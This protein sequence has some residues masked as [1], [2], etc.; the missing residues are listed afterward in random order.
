MAVVK[1]YSEVKIVLVGVPLMNTRVPPLSLA[2]LRA[3]MLQDGYA[4]KCFDFNIET[5]RSVVPELKEQWTF[6]KGLQWLDNSY[7]ESFVYPNII[8]KNL[9]HWVSQILREKPAVVGISMTSSPSGILLAHELK[10]AKPDLKIIIGGPGCSKSF[11]NGN[12]S[13][14][15][16][17]DAVVHNEGELTLSALMKSYK[18]TGKFQ[19]V[20]GASVMGPNGE[21]LFTGLREPQMD[22][23]I[24]PT[25][26][27][28]D[29]NFEYY[30]D[31]DDPQQMRREIPYYATRG[32]P[33]RC[34][35][36]MDYKMWDNR[37]R[38]KSPAR[39]IQEMVFLS[40]KYKIKNFMLIELIFNGHMAKLKI[41]AE[42]LAKLKMGFQ[43]WGHGRIDP[44]LDRTTIQLLKDCGFF[45]FVF[46]L[47]SGSDKVLKAMRK[48]YNKETA[49]R[50][51][52]DMGEVG[53]LCSVNIVIGFPGE[54]WDDFWETIELVHKH[55]KAIAGPPSLS[56]CNAMPGSDIYLYPEK[57][58]IKTK[59]GEPPQ[60]L[61][62]ETVDGT[63]TQ[64]IRFF[65]RD[66]MRKYFFKFRFKPMG[67][68]HEDIELKDIPNPYVEYQKMK[69]EQK[70]KFEQEK[71]LST[72][73]QI[74]KKRKVIAKSKR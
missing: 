64:E 56:A 14:G 36:C 59:N 65:R 1:E 46:G 54:D 58:G 66:F 61:E 48:G 28:D 5:Y 38:Q 31:A 43:F 29:F 32:C 57:F 20:P 7:F 16:L 10:R 3:Q 27:F 49:D 12:F 23:D 21:V 60:V 4:V 19:S 6:Y 25:P 44:R 18:E 40:E 62:W 53:L 71:L 74:P 50:V 33:A 13:P 22:L 26:D 55:R 9:P 41:F 35:F 30:L 52:K 67:E 24:M 15:P 45:M 47:E 63:N 39:I 42:E 37:Y 11:A 17:Y 69:L 2:L 73:V 34:N 8:G 72:A 70:V 51:L 68:D